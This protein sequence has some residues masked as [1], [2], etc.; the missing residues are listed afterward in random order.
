MMKKNLSQMLTAIF[1]CGVMLLACGFMMTTMT[2]CGSDDDEPAGNGIDDLAYLQKRIANEGSL[3]Y[4]VQLGTDTKDI[5]SRPVASTARAQEEF[6]KLIPGGSAHQGLSTAKDGT[7]TCR[8]TDK[9][10]KSQGTITY[11]PSQS[12]TVYYCAEV[13]FSQEVKSATG[14]SCLRYVLIDRWPEDGN[15]FIKDILDS[16]KQ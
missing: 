4:G 11:Q 14:I 8:L 1:S 16:I 2:A 7:I 13:A 10:G 3:V 12:A 5:V 6:Y 15:G 9:D